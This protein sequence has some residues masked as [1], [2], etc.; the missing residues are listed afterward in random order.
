M[1]KKFERTVDQTDSNPL[2]G[3]LGDRKKNTNKVDID[4]KTIKNQ[5]NKK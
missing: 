1:A 2:S 5:K 3:E 4:E